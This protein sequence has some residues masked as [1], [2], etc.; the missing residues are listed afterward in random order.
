MG[1]FS[2]SSLLGPLQIGPALSWE[3]ILSLPAQNT[4]LQQEVT[5]RRKRLRSREEYRKRGLNLPKRIIE[6]LFT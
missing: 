3:V 5:L 1:P 2:G 4:E 6:H